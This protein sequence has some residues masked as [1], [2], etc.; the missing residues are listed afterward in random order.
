MLKAKVNNKFDFTVDGDAEKG[1]DLIEV[2]EGIFHI[3]KDSKSYTAEVLKAN[4]EE[5]VL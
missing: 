5:K 2:K 4:R 1:I 3:I